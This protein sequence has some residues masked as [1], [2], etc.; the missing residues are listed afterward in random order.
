MI[1]RESKLELEKLLMILPTI[2]AETFRSK[3]G[4]VLI[5]SKCVETQLLDSSPHAFSL[6]LLSTHF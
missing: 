4:F 2:I 3:E 1:T 5:E 6:L